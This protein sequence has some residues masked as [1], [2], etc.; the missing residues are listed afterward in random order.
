MAPVRIGTMPDGRDVMAHTLRAEPGVELTVLD[1]GATVQ[2][3]RVPT[4]DG[5]PLDAVL[6]YSDVAS[7]LSP[8][9][10]SVG[11]TVGRYANR[12]AGGRFTL[13]GKTYP[14]TTNEA[15]T[16]LHGGTEGFHLRLWTVVDQAAGSLTHGTRQPRR[17]PRVPRE[18]TAGAAYRVAGDTVTI[19]L[20]ATCDAP[21]VVSLTNHVYFNLGG[22]E[23][24][25]AEDHL[26]AVDA[27]PYLRSILAPFPWGGWIRSP[28]RPSTSRRRPRSATGLVTT[29]NRYCGW[30]VSTTPT[31]CAARACAERR[32]WNIRTVEAS[33]RSAP[34]SRRCRS[35]PVT[36][37]TAR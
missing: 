28:E 12:I 20:S 30:P 14:L 37:S 34:T 33:W 36:A 25:S 13:D 21:T 8:T 24:G 18:L 9:N 23:S 16:C 27:D 11:A 17:G 29:I 5:H 2:R 19:E 6:G 4:R 7:Y 22:P 1:L 15:D 32:G 35:T 3:L 31:T 26:L 10:P